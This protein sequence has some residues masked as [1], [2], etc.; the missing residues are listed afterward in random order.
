MSMIL[1]PKELIGK[2]DFVFG[3][4]VLKDNVKLTN[5]ENKVFE[6]YKEAIEYSQKHRYD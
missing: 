5:E 6:K 2:I 4:V 1:P 3:S